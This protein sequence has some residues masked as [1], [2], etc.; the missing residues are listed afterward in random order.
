MLFSLI[1]AT[2][3][4]YDALEHFLDSLKKQTFRDFEVILADQ[5][6]PG[7]L[8]PL[9]KA[10][11]GLF[12]LKAVPVPPHGASSARNAVLIEAQGEIIAFPDD[13]CQYAPHALAGIQALFAARPGLGGLIV[14]WSDSFPT[15][16]SEFPLS[17]VSRTDA[18]RNAGTLVQFYCR[19]AIAGLS[20]DPELGPGTGL[21]YGCG[22]DTDFLLQA[23]ARGAAVRRTEEVFIRHARPDF[24]DPAL[25]AKVRSY[26][27]GRM[28]I[29]RKH[30]FPIW[31]RLANVAYPLARWLPDMITL[32]PPGARYRWNMFRGRLS[33][34]FHA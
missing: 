22:E 3:N 19:E 2:Y 12:P 23:L 1:V 4:R 27:L 30:D 14:G 20:F 7:F 6:P 17:P 18:F 11:G 13:D 5:N 24:S 32:G 21:P 31:F 8:A 34:L 9:L 29:L 15:P 16:P 10:Y 28:R 25:A 33:G 26:A